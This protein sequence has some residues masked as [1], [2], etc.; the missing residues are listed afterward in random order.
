MSDTWHIIGRGSISLLAASQLVKQG[1]EVELITKDDVCQRQ[2]NQ[3]TITNLADQQSQFSVLQSNYQS[4]TAIQ[5][6]L[7]PLKAYDILPAIKQIQSRVT[8]QTVIILCHNGMGTIKPVQQL[9]GKQQPLLF[10]TTTHGAYRKSIHHVVHCGLGETKIGWLNHPSHSPS[11]D[12]LNQM[13]QPL[14][15]HQDISAV[16]WQK[17]AINCVINPLTAIHQCQNGHLANEAF[18]TNIVGLC[19]EVSLV[20]N[21]CGLPL[22]PQQLQ[23]DCYQVIKATAKNYSSMNRDVAANRRTEINFITGYLIEK[24]RQYGIKTPLNSELYQQV[25]GLFNP[26]SGHLAIKTP[27]I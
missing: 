24:A 13:L 4:Q 18:A 27:R 8:P 23:Q 2:T 3:I 16:L 20:A 12:K 19:Q 26:N 9:L 11:T 15:W 21:A 17:L 6:L 5:T 10:A 1:Y 22:T 7:V 25:N 14:S